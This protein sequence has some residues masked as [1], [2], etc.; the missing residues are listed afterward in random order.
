M[1]PW[2]CKLPRGLI[3][4]SSSRTWTLSFHNRWMHSQSKTWVALAWCI[5]FACC[6][7]FTFCSSPSEALNPDNVQR[8]ALHS[9]YLPENQNRQHGD[10]TIRVQWMKKF[11]KHVPH[12]LY[13]LLWDS[14]PVA[15]YWLSIIRMQGFFSLLFLFCFCLFSLLMCVFL[16]NSLLLYVLDAGS[17]NSSRGEQCD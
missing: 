5:F 13:S 12:R 6:S 10:L 15:F 3:H 17:N 7:T 4:A 11:E 16:F 1:W 2:W 14:R 8:L 9:I